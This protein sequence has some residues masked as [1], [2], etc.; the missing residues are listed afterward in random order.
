MHLIDPGKHDPSP[1]PY[2][3]RFQRFEVNLR[4]RE[5]S[6]D[7]RKIKLP[8]QSFQILA[9]LLE[10]PQEVVMR[11]EIRK[12]LWPNDTVVEFENSIHAAV[13][14]LR[15]ALEDAAESP[16]FIE[17]L[18]RRGYR[19]IVPVE[20]MDFRPQNS[21]LQAAETT[22]T[23]ANPAANLIAK[24]VS[25]YRV[26]QVLGGGGMGV[27]Y[28]AEDIKLGRRVALKFLPEELANDPTA[29]E[30]LDREAR[31]ASALNHPNICT[32]YAVEEHQGQP[33]IAMELLDGQ[34]L[35]EVISEAE[36]NETH[37]KTRNGPMP[38]G[39]LLDIA[40]QTLQGVDAAHKKDII[41]RDIKP[42]NIFIT[43]SG[44]VKI[45][46][47]GLAKLNESK[48]V[49]GEESEQ[50]D[51]A[52]RTGA[53]NVFH[54]N[55]NLTRTGD[56]MGTAGYMSPEQVRGEE[57]DI[58]TDLFSFG[59]VL[60]EI[61][62][63]QRA[64]TGETRPAL[65]EAILQQAPAPVRELNP[66]VP[67]KLERIID[68]AIEKDRS[69]RYQTAERIRT[70]LES[71]RRDLKPIP[72]MRWWA[73]C[74]GIAAMLAVSTTFWRARSHPP[75]PAAEI[76][77]RQLT[78]NSAENHVISAAIS[79]DGRLLAYSDIKGLHIKHIETGELEHVSQPPALKGRDVEWEPVFWLADGRT[80]VANLHPSGI[81]P[82]WDSAGSSI[83]ALPL[84]GGA[85]RK[86]R[87]NAVAYT[88]SP[89]GSQ[90]SFGTNKGGLGDREM[91]LM[92]PTG[93]H[94]RK[95]FETD[96]NHAIGGNDWSPHGRRILYPDIDAAGHTLVSRDIETGIVNT[97][98]TRSQTQGV[99]QH[100]WLADG[101][102]IYARNEDQAIGNISN[103]WT[104]RL[105][106][107]PGE[108]LEK[109][110]Q[111][112]N[113][114]GFEIASIT[115]TKD[116][117]RL[118]F[119]QW[120]FHATVYVAD[121]EADGAR[122]RNP[123]HFTLTDSA[124]LPADWTQDSKAIILLSNRTG[125]AGIYKQSL[126]EEA[127]ELLVTTRSGIIQPRATPD[128]KWVL[129]LS[130]TNPRIARRP[131][132]ARVPITGGSSERMFPVRPGS[133]LLCARDPANV[134]AIA[135]PGEDL[136]EVIVTALNPL[137]GRGSELMRF[138]VDPSVTWAV[139]L[140]PDGNRI[141]V[142]TH[143]AGPIQILSLRGQP[144]QIIQPKGLNNIQFMHW[145]ANG[146]GLYVSTGARGGRA[147]WHVDLQGNTNLLWENRG[148]DWAPGLPS[149]DGRHMAIESS[150]NSS[151]VWMIENF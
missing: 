106:E 54:A 124:D 121:L 2:L 27:V 65:H 88:I 51:L 58:R 99:N 83:W 146:H 43:S 55:P 69:A 134:C 107:R 23:E 101:R 133:L 123:T 136:K 73:A 85:A 3:I 70:D 42:A 50:L 22:T 31:A 7:G 61:A 115:G 60:Y 86:L 89:D 122:I 90:I 74:S 78:T 94:P 91:W 84:L 109:P 4:S 102:L 118:A 17:T 37:G 128:G 28:S 57:L 1:A 111:L 77:L 117:K 18:A 96:E 53:E 48:G 5:L 36:A 137:R 105:D 47:F 9:M 32:I 87:D 13:R 112:T 113:W 144:V 56:T 15:L 11:A 44:Q 143:P 92:G 33:F 45:L 40:L 68:K 140:A 67:V 72:R 24:K 132:L 142:L 138:K 126:E 110:H 71:L 26:L 6:K 39:K 20:A 129:Y 49:K 12:R 103:L 104:M 19:W 8:E 131:Q 81:G 125:R 135:E 25:H 116:G 30:R 35:Q 10:R 63:G 80:F 64:F 119:L 41:H 14:R 98:L 97:V 120:A 145:A 66:R 62:A 34:T 147:L 82:Y 148:G 29:I 59:L 93:E 79:P 100:W 75:V 139:D 16:R 130:D 150:D 21:V 52:P 149:P 151:N 38:I 127:P 46:D 141:A 108:P 76:K 95:L 114:T